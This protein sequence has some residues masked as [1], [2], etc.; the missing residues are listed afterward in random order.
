MLCRRRRSP[1]PPPPPPH[2]TFDSSDLM[3]AL[4]DVECCDFQ[5]APSFVAVEPRSDTNP[6]PFAAAAFYSHDSSEV[7]LF[8]FCFPTF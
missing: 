8:R 5:P 2:S 6:V 3:D 1:P 7:E 4:D